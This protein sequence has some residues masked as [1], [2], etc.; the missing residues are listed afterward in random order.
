MKI[1]LCAVVL[2]VACGH[3]TKVRVRTDTAPP[4]VPESVPES[5][6]APA[7]RMLADS[8]VLLVRANVA[9]ILAGLPEKNICG[10]PE[11]A[12]TSKALGTKGAETMMLL[13]ILESMVEDTIKEIPPERDMLFAALERFRSSCPDADALCS[14]PDSERVCYEMYK[15]IFVAARVYAEAL[16]TSLR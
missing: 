3:A 10:T 16:A 15:D 9:A 2:L 7:D 12:A 8:V 1:L 5:S 11:F 6:P 4:A 14:S 13:G